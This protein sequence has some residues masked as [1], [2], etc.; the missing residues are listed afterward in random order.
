[1]AY[2][3]WKHSSDTTEGKLKKFFSQN[4]FFAFALTS[5]TILFCIASETRYE[6][7]SRQ[8][9]ELNSFYLEFEELQSDVHTYSSGANDSL[10]LSIK[11]HLSKLNDSMAFLVNLEISTIYQRDIQDVALMLENYTRCAESIIVHRQH[12][13]SDT[14]DSSW[15]TQINQSYYEAQEIYHSINAEFRGLY[16]QIL[17][18][19]R[20]MMDH[21][22]ATHRVFIT[23]VILILIFMLIGEFAYSVML[24]H[25]ITD[26]IRE[27]TSSIRDFS[28]QKL[29]EYQQVHLS[30]ASN[31]EMN[32]LVTVFN[33]MLQ[34]I[35]EQ[36][37]QIRANADATIKLHQKEVENLQI[38][39]LLRSSELKALQMQINP[40]FLFNTLNMISQTA[41][42]EGADKT[43]LLLDSTAAL[44]RYT[45]DFA[46]RAVPLSKEIEILGIYVSLQ[47]QRFG[48]RIRFTFDLDESFHHI[49][50]PSLILQPLV[51]NAI[52][53]GIGMY[54]KN[55]FVIIRTEY[56]DSRNLGI[57]RVIDNG[58]GMEKEQLEKVCADM[59]EPSNAEQKIGLSN[60][61]TRLHIF[62]YGKATMEIRSVPNV[63]TEVTIFIP[64]SLS[65]RDSEVEQ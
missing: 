26:P 65:D 47:E 29:T 53:H 7:S 49:K 60:V 43:S 28:V 61:Y 22:K 24:S 17:E 59:K 40:H 52:T 10:D 41:Y 48:G 34:T 55:A 14:D 62:F 50:V 11:E 3:Q 20:V 36:F 38:T 13:F 54:L 57:I 44:L 8:Q 18:F 46:S 1:M 32:V 39:N 15:I 56:D 42:V 27:L 21:Q 45:L 37:K 30:S 63:E 19:A 64:C 23:T 5:I 4:L 16:S 33:T 9:L 58:I 31:P 35:Q 51:E 2:L 12:S 6:Q 25:I